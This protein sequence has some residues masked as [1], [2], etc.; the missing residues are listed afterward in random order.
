MINSLCYRRSLLKKLH[1]KEIKFNGGFRL[2]ILLKPVRK[3]EAQLLRNLYS[4]YLHD[5][6]LYTNNLD[7]EVD[8]QFEFNGFKSFWVEEGISPYL[9]KDEADA[10]I[11]FMLLLERP[12]LQK[13]HDYSVNDIFILNKYRGKGYGKQVLEQLFIK[14]PGKYY[15]IQLR[16]NE[17]AISFWKKIYEQ[18][19]IEFH[20]RQEQIGDD[21]C[22]VQTFQV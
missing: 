10:I 14:K 4:L 7:I 17:P 16:K 21:D 20:E 11:G 8:G 1:L 12:L 22:I 2:T 15:V 18:L 13:E 19:N 3:R 6:S 9:L 5:L